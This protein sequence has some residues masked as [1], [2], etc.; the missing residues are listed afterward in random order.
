MWNII[1]SSSSNSSNGKGD[2][3]H[4]PF[5]SSL[6]QVVHNERNIGLIHTG[7]EKLVLV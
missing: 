6:T 7:E 5:M 1:I 2:F 4:T 3:Y